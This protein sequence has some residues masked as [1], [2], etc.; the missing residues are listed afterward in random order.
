MLLG[1]RL[2]PLPEL[3]LRELEL[4]LRPVLLRLP[5]LR[6]PTHVQG[7]I[8]EIRNMITSSLIR[9][10]PFKVTPP[11][12]RSIFSIYRRHG[13]DHREGS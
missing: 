4:C 12:I 9:L 2:A 6:R 5:H 11:N 3:Q 7:E 8:S 13:H 10:Q 1:P